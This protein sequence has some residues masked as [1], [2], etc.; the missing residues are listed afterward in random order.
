MEEKMLWFGVVHPVA[1]VGFVL[2]MAGTFHLLLQSLAIRKH[3]QRRLSV[4]IDMR[5][6]SWWSICLSAILI[7]AGALL[8]ANSPAINVYVKLPWSP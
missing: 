5:A 6:C 4:R 7:A 8:I 1:G 2:I 3:R